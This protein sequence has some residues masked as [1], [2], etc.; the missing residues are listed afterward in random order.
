VR[1]ILEVSEN[2]KAALK[3]KAQAQGLSAE[4]FVR[5]VLARELEV[6][7]EP[8]WRAFTHRMHSLPDEVFTSLPADGASE[9]DHYLYG[10]PKRTMAELPKSIRSE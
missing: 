5:Q 4:D 3:A 10:S 1:L 7:P 2:Q 9:H 6:D 8:F